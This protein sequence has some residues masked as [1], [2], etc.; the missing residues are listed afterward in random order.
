MSCVYK[1]TFPNGA[2]YIGKTDMK[3]EHRWLNGW[4][5]KNCPLMFAAILQ[6]GWYNVKHEIIADGLTPQEAREIES[7]EISK[8]SMS[9]TVVYNVAQLS[10]QYHAQENA[11]YLDCTQPHKH[12]DPHSIRS[13]AQSSARSSTKTPPLTHY[14]Q[15][16]IPI[17]KKPEGYRYCP[18]DVYYKTGE[19]ICTY[20][21][22]KIAA[23]EL[24][25]SRGDVISC[26]KGVRADGMPRY[27]VKGYIFRYHIENEVG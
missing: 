11:H 25:V 7:T 26:C 14:K 20:P 21:S 3:P 15:H 17:T 18:I 10:A 8:H 27:Q 19:F 4:G 13:S 24:N 16:I 6:F 1:H 2:V 12:I 5:Y 22:A 9:S 23:S